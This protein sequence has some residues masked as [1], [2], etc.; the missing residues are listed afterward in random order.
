MLG[1]TD[2]PGDVEEAVDAATMFYHIDGGSG[3]LGGAQLGVL[4]SAL[5][6]RPKKMTEPPPV[7]VDFRRQPQDGSVKVQVHHDEEWRDGVFLGMIDT[8]LAVRLDGESE[9]REF[10]PLQTRLAP[11]AKPKTQKKTTKRRGR[12]SEAVATA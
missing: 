10:S 11:T 3:P 8:T 9:I 5:G 4:L 1:E 2:L 6:Y 12:A 7:H